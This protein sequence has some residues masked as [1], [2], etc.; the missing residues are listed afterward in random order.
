[1]VRIGAT[2]GLPAVLQRLG[3]RPAQL[4]AEVGRDLSLFDNP[5]N[6]ISFAAR[7]RLFSPWFASSMPTP[8][9]RT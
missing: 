5:D 8:G 2:I 9:L 3:A 7:G 1:M 4:L 6:L